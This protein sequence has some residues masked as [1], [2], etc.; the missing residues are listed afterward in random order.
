MKK[1][2]LLFICLTGLL[3]AQPIVGVKITRQDNGLPIADRVISLQTS[4]GNI[5]QNVPTNSLGIAWFNWVNEG[6]YVYKVVDCNGD[7]VAASF[8]VPPGAD[9]LFYTTPVC[10]PPGTDCTGSLA[11]D[12]YPYSPTD[13]NAFF[14]ISNSLSSPITQVYIDYGDGTV[15]P[16]AFGSSHS[17][18]YATA[19]MYTVEI[20]AHTSDV[21]NIGCTMHIIQTIEA[22]SI[23]C[24]AAFNYTVDGSNPLVYNF[25]AVNPDTVHV[26][27]YWL[28]GNG[29]GFSSIPNSDFTGSITNGTYTRTFN[30]RGMYI[31]GRQVENLN[32]NCNDIQFDTL[33]V[34]NV[35]LA[36][37]YTLEV[38]S[39]VTGVPVGTIYKL[40]SY[41]DN[42]LFQY[43]TIDGV[44]GG[45]VYMY[46]DSTASLSFSS[47]GT[48][49]VCLIT[50]LNT[51][52][53]DFGGDTACTQI[54][55]SP[56]L[57]ICNAGF[58][59]QI[60]TA[61]SVIN[62]TA[63]TSSNTHYWEFEGTMFD[64]SVFPNPSYQS[65]PGDTVFVMH[66]I[67]I[68][69]SNCSDTLY[70]TIVMPTPPP[71][72]VAAGFTYSVDSVSALISFIN[73]TT[74][75]TT[76]SWAFANGSTTTSTL[77][78]PTF[79]S[80]LGDTVTVT[81]IAASGTC[82]DTSVV[83]IYMPEPP[84]AHQLTGCAFIN[85]N[86]AGDAIVYLLRLD[87]V[88]D[89]IVLTDS[90]STSAQGCYSF[91]NITNGDYIIKA[92]L[93]PANADVATTLPT[94]HL[95]SANWTDADIFTVSGSG[96][97][98]AK[99][100]NMIT[101]SNPGGPGFIGGNVNWL[102]TLF[103]STVDYSFTTVI[104]KDSNGQIITYTRA[105]N[106]GN[107]AFT[108]IPL[109]NFNVSAD[110][111]GYITDTIDVTLTVD[112]PSASDVTVGIEQSPL[113]I[114]EVSPVTSVSLY[115]NPANETTTLQINAT[116]NNA[117]ALKVVNMLGQTVVAKNVTLQAGNNYQTIDIAGFSK[118][119]YYISL[120]IKGKQYAQ[121]LI[122][123]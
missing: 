74:G 80:G 110:Y 84:P 29:G 71:C 59:Y 36:A 42:A 68:P 32:V 62:F 15:E 26:N 3:Y 116:T 45:Q 66:V 55:I 114:K 65:V 5:Y 7:S 89:E 53:V 86:P 96:Q 61:T 79:Q 10:T 17:H 14:N 37:T 91:D 115:P 22:Y 77:A 13:I 18:L 107:F 119:I 109:G 112:Q 44:Y 30:D 21:E 113:S 87:Y 1:L 43:Y 54:T 31:F 111:A 95:S 58:T 8:T 83:V 24:N 70:D 75:A 81:L 63:Q 9:T 52:G 104:L 4:D 101:G 78:N 82:T 6:D 92:A 20:Y 27:A 12:I 100:F 98:P 38:D 47:P 90:V 94:Y 34:G 108:N 49:D 16:F 88:N 56:S 41:S 39:N 106:A 50:G 67:S 46:S 23:D 102:D 99:D 25:Q 57:F 118:G 11:V 93:A 2:T 97:L 121:K 51:N 19:G 85:S 69:V 60:D 122:K 120:T 64:N 40:K 105:D 48:Y 123:Y 72:T 73:T 76:Y 103:R 35:Q 33:N 28:L 117:C